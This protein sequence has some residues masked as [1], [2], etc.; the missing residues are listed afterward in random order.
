M[1]GADGGQQRPRGLALLA[2]AAEQGHLG[3]QSLLGRTAFGDLMTT[4]QGP[5]LTEDYVHALKYLRAAALRGDEAT[6]DWIPGIGTAQVLDDG[7]FEPPLEPPLA[8][9]EPEWVRRAWRAADALV[10]CAEER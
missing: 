1:K 7:S 3:A 8:D 2:E 5:E 6:L 4:G 10:R 9:L